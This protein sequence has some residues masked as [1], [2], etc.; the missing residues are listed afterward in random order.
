MIQ[1]ISKTF[2]HKVVRDRKSGLRWEKGIFFIA[3]DNIAYRSTAAD[4]AAVMEVYAF[5]KK[6][7]KEIEARPTQTTLL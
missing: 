1:R 4:P 5:K 7:K 6:I 2:Y 3:A